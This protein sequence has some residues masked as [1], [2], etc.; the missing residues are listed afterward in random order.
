MLHHNPP[1][2]T[3]PSNPGFS[4]T[5]IADDH[6]VC[7]RNDTDNEAAALFRANTSYIQDGGVYNRTF[8]LVTDGLNCTK[9]GCEKTLDGAVVTPRCETEHADGHTYTTCYAKVNDMERV[10]VSRTRDGKENDPMGYSI[11]TDG[12]NCTVQ[13]LDSSHLHGDAK[14]SVSADKR[15]LTVTSPQ[16]GDTVA[17]TFDTPLFADQ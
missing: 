5:H 16:N 17:F 6:Y 15:Q 11:G 7:T 3:T 8:T 12:P 2:M 4:C 10:A 14:C 9:D 1:A 13:K